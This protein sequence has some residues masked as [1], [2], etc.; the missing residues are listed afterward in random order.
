MFPNQI[1]FPDQEVAAVAVLVTVAVDQEAHLVPGAAAGTAQDRGPLPERGAGPGA[2]TRIPG[3]DLA[4]VR[5][6]QRRTGPITTELIL[7]SRFS[8]KKCRSFCHKWMR[9]LRLISF[10]LSSVLCRMEHFV[11]KLTHYVIE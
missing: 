6:P 1:V 7:G 10:L 3:R 9:C 4:V 8:V 11:G 2:R 5:L